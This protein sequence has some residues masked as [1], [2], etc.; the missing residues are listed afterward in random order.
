M[1]DAGRELHE[2]YGNF[3]KLNNPEDVIYAR[4][5]ASP[6]AIVS[7][8]LFLAGLFP[9]TYLFTWKHNLL[10]NPLPFIVI[11]TRYDKV[12]YYFILFYESRKFYYSTLSYFSYYKVINV[13]IIEKFIKNILLPLKI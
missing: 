3:L 13:Q 1:Y 9:P 5:T 7:M 11:P 10:W 2:K 6:R 12:I 4:S 8:Q